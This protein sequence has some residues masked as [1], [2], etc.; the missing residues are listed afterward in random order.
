[1]DWISASS[2]FGN[3]DQRKVARDEK[4][5]FTLDTVAVYDRSW[6][7]ET[8]VAHKDFYGGGWIILEGCDTKEE[9]VEMHNKWLKVFE[10]D[11]INILID[12]YDNSLYERKGYKINEK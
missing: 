1:M 6:N 12:Y 2:M 3:Y 4:G 9:A 8:A 11:T 5:F 7:Y 10:K